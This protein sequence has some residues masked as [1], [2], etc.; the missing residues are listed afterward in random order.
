MQ[1]THTNSRQTRL[2]IWRQIRWNLILYSVLLA[3]LPI[4]V[5]TALVVPQRNA[6]D[7]TEITGQLEATNQLKANQISDWLNEAQLGLGLVLADPQTYAEFSSLITATET[8]T[9]QQDEVNSLLVN[10]ND[11]HPTYENFF[12][13]RA[14]GEVVASSD[15]DDVGKTV[16]R[17]PYFASSLTQSTF[18]QPPFYE[19]GNRQLALFI[20]KLI[21]DEQGQPLGAFASRI[22]L[23]TMGEIMQESIGGYSQT[24]ETYLV[25]SQTNYLLT[26]SR[27]EG[28]SLTQS[29]QSEG[30]N[31][32]LEQQTGSGRYVSYRGQPV[33][34]AYRWLPELQAGLMAEVDEGEAL[35][36]SVSAQNTNILIALLAAV[37]AV[38]FGFYYASSVAKPIV[39]LTQ[40][41]AAI[42]AGNYSQRVSVSSRNE[43]GQLTAAFNTMTGELNKN[44]GALKVLNEELEQRVATRTRDLQVASDVSRQITRVLDRAQL[45]EQLVVMTRRSFNLYHVSI[46]LYDEQ[47]HTLQLEAAT[48]DAGLAMLNDGKQFKLND[49]GLVPLAGRERRSIIIDDTRASSDFFANPYLPETRSEIALPMVIGS[50]L[51]GVLDLQSQE[52]ARFTEQE[53]GVLTTLAEQIAISVRNA[54]LFTEAASARD[55][56]ERAN[57]VKSMFLASMSH[58]LRTPLNAVINFTKFVVKGIMGPVNERQK[59]TLGT[60]IDSANHLL[61]LI[62]DVLDM[63]K[64]ESGSLNLFIEE[65]VSLNEILNS[66]ASTATSL[67]GD[68]TVQLR[69]EIADDLP[70]L[71]GDRQR[72]MQI[73]LNIVSNACKFTEEGQITISA[74][75]QFDTV[76]LMVRDT[77]PGIAPEDQPAVFQPFRQTETGLRQG[78]GTGLGMP[79]SKSL[80]EAHDGTMWLESTPGEGASFYVVLPVKSDKLVPSL[81][82]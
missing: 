63:S 17:Q 38:V 59:E 5:V 53:L 61:N 16:S 39:T 74:Q 2:P 58:E 47:K 82:N 49:R 4:T 51:V 36:A 54:Q 77:G 76:Q 56:A 1:T 37:V 52:A 44:I 13:Y 80:V 8:D 66:V 24:G 57:Q 21:V 28:Y 79:I 18:V 27:F 23:G 67:L 71:V 75:P 11:A 69:L 7:I 9:T 10:L 29:Y 26:P 73:L 50:Q 45:L 43:L 41:A 78:G 62:N 3:A 30:I 25:S 6:Q 72:I 65:H 81:V 33:I 35:A 19:L 22:E 46:F 60:V 42:T 40:A 48:G 14:D 64:I 68:K 34:G 15:A 55:Q 12:L 32:A 70:E 20:T 31:Q